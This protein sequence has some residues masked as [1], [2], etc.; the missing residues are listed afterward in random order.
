M[1]VV[2][3]KADGAVA[4]VEAKAEPPSDRTT[5]P[6][7][8]RDELGDRFKGVVLHTGDQLVPFGDKPWLAPL[9]ALWAE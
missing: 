9:P 6:P 2:L 1:D 5:S 8:M 7:K 3:E 4:G